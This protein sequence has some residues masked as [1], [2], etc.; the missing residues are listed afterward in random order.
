MRQQKKTTLKQI[1]SQNIRSFRLESG[2]TQQQLADE[3][4]FQVSYIARLEGTDQN[5]S[6][7]VL[8]RIAHALDRE[9][10]ELVSQKNV[11]LTSKKTMA[12]FE[13][14]INLLRVVQSRIRP[15]DD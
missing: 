12:M 2:L 8:E 6:L 15:M 7:D 5:L 9:I 14:A 10:S 3:A 13:Q 11:A 4:G 1:V